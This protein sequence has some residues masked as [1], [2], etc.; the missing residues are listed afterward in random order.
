[1]HINCSFR[2]FCTVFVL[3]FICVV[4]FRDLLCQQFRITV[5]V[6]HTIHGKLSLAAWATKRINARMYA[7]PNPMLDHFFLIDSLAMCDELS[8]KQI[9]FECVFVV[10]EW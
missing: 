9:M 2:K 1:M 6:D 8:D 3:L 7:M 5:A 10:Y 4:K